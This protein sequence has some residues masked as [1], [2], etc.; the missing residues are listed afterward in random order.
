MQVQ[1]IMT[2]APLKCGPQATLADAAALMWHGDCGIVPVVDDAGHVLGVLTDR[3]I[4]IAAWS[5]NRPLAEISAR[6]LLRR[7]PVT[8][9]PTDDVQVA[10]S[11]MH[12]H[13][14]R[15]L[16]VVDEHGILEGILSIN[17]V[18][19][20]AGGTF[21]V[22]PTEVLEAFKGIGTHHSMVL[23]A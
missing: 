19:L 9:R 20:A 7:E 21:D 13:R 2:I 22:N 1:H 10:L 23:V 12:D 11:L 6:D 4:C 5:Q 15:R 16:P 18:V 3:D 14:V 17:D 8:C